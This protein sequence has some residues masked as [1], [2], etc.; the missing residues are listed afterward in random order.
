MWT[1]Y[2]SEVGRRIYAGFLVVLFGGMIAATTHSWLWV[3]IFCWHRLHYHL[4]W[5]TLWLLSSYFL[6]G[7]IAS[8]EVLMG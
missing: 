8:S 6:I 7:H 5:S 1:Y 2:A 3:L 4:L